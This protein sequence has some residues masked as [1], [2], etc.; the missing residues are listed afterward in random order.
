MDEI[1]RSLQADARVLDLGSALGSFPAWRSN[2]QRIVRIDLEAPATPSQ[3][4]VQCHAAHLPFPPETFDAVIANHSLEHIAPLAPALC[5]L[6][7]VMKPTAQ[8][9]VAVPDAAS[10]SDRL[11]R[12][13]YHG[14][15]HVN[16]FT[17]PGEVVA[18][19]SE[20]TGLPLA[21]FRELRT[22]YGFLERRHFHPRPPRRLF[23]FANGNIGV[24]TFMN[25]AARI[26]D[27]YLRT[28]LSSYGWAFYFGAC[29][30]EI[31]TSVWSNVCAGCGS[32]HNS[33]W[34]TAAGLVR[35]RSLNFVYDCPDCGVLN[36]FTHDNQSPSA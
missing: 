2:T 5:E 25:Y 14:G 9:F 36:Y 22:S 7:R 19:V 35:R 16:A 24:I 4:F 17:S 31:D 11:Y 12:W 8:L 21:A 34:L 3:G 13:V 15:G 1:L 28:R 10:P 18:L 6:R 30:A 32:S 29:R 33:A 23:L 27:R 26:L 20:L